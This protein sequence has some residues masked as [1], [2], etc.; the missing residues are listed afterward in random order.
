MSKV[1]VV[2]YGMGNV[3]SVMR[4]IEHVGATAILSDDPK[5]IRNADRVILPGVGAFE[6]GMKELRHRNIDYALDEFIETER[7]LLGI[8]L[9]MQMLFDKSKEHGDHAGLGFISGQVVQIPGNKNGSD[10]RKIPHIGWSALRYSNDSTNWN[11]TVLDGTIEGEFFYFIH[12]F[13]VLPDEKE[14]ILAQCKYEGISISAT[15]TK[16]N[17]TGCQFHPEKSGESGLKVL[18]RF[19]RM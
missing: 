7:P 19:L 6:D 8:C 1:V 4:G 15:I 2:S 18:D 9:G 3:K 13:M 5:L 17:V 10:K 16:N 11:N 14:C 12:S